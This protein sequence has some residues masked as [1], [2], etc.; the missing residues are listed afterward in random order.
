MSHYIRPME[1]GGAHSLLLGYNKL[2]IVNI[3]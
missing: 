2:I 3:S 1:A